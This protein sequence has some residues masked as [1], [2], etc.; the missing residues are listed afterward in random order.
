MA[1]EMH[2]HSSKQILVTEYKDL[3]HSKCFAALESC[4]SWQRC[5]GFHGNLAMK[6]LPWVF[7]GCR[8]YS[9]DWILQV[10]ESLPKH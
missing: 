5:K 4:L 3:Y 7:Q 10:G 1:S 6:P 9:R 2:G 8:L